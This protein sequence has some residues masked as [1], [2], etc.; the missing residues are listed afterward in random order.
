MTNTSERR[1]IVLALVFLGIVVSYVDRGNLSIAAETIMRDLRL[2]PKS[3]G[4]L[5][6]AFF[7]TYAICQIPAG[8]LV[9]RFGIRSVYASAFLVWSLASASIALSR[10]WHDILASR[11]ALGFAESIGPLASLAFIRAHYAAREQGLPVSIYIAGQNLGPAIGALLGATLLTDFGWRAMFALTGLGALIWV[12]VWLYFAP[13]P[14]RAAAVNS[15][16]AGKLHWRAILASPAFWTMSAASFF[17]SYYWYFLLTWM[18]AYM[19]MARGFSTLGMGRILSTPLFVMAASNV[20]AGWLADRLSSR[21]GKPFWVRI[22][23]AASGLTGAASILLLNVT[24]GRAPVLPILVLSICSF[25][26]ASSNFWTISQSASPVSLVGRVIGF[27]NTLSQVAGAVAPIVTGWSLGPQ[28]DFRFAI[29]IAGICPL[30]AAACLIV[31]GRS[32]PE[33]TAALE[34]RNDVTVRP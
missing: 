13:R 27:L 14:S 18:P 31:A 26:I 10:G 12:P 2:D 21:T 33:L 28:K 23:F 19:T 34:R 8:L 1:W 5:L 9:D 30:I 6:S 32:L 17:L 3:M 24:A 20:L 15:S 7:W 22:G 4:V 11:L 16:V 25:G 29:L